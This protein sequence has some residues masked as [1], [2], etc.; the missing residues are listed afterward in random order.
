M[1]ALPPI[2][3]VTV[4]AQSDTIPWDYGVGQLGSS[5]RERASQ[6][7]VGLKPSRVQAGVEVAVLYGAAAADDVAVVQADAVARAD[8]M[9]QLAQVPHV[10]EIARAHGAAPVVVIA[11]ATVAASIRTGPGR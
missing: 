5:P 11:D 10:L 3:G 8:T 4:A 6:L 7:D 2:V 1:F 9:S